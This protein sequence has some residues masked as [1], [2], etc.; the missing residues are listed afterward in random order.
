[1]AE[2]SAIIPE[3][4]LETNETKSSKKWVWILVITLLLAGAGGAW[5]FLAPHE[6]ANSTEAD[7]NIDAE[8]EVEAEPEQHAPPVFVELEPFTVNL[9]S[10]GQMLQATFNLQVKNEKVAE[11]IKL[12]MPQIRSRLLIMLSN[13]TAESLGKQEGKITLISEIESLVEQPFTKGAKPVNIINVFVTSF[14][15]Q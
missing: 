13:K 7:T 6:K 12:Y 2:L 8:A 14:I 11:E 1:M 4:E 10:D 5:Y 9:Q 15:I 3:S